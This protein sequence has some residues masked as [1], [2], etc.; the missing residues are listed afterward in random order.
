M[1]FC[2]YDV[3]MVYIVSDVEE[4]IVESEVNYKLFIFCLGEECFD[5][6]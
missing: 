2:E 1:V 5:I 4:F 3:S 6:L